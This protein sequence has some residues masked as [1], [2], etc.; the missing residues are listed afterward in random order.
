ML[1][2]IATVV[3]WLGFIATLIVGYLIFF[4]MQDMGP[5]WFKL[6]F[7]L[8][9]NTIAWVVAYILAGSRGFFPFGE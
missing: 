6:I 2:R 5:F 1:D 8:A 7:T 4:D 9:P 3:H